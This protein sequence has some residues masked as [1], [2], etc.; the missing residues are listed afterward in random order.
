MTH[1]PIEDNA[2]SVRLMG[3]YRINS[4]VL[5]P[6]QELYKPIRTYTKQQNLELKVPLY[7]TIGQDAFSPSNHRVALYS[8]S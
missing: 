6:I 5:A 7:K 2:H 8:S 3:T 1:F 4:D